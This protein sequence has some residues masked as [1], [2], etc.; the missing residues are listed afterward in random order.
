MKHL[1]WGLMVAA[2]VGCATQAQNDSVRAYG[3]RL[4][5]SDAV[6]LGPAVPMQYYTGDYLSVAS[7]GSEHLV[8]FYD[9]GRV[10]GVRLDEQGN[11]LDLERWLPLGRNDD[12]DGSQAYTDVTF[13]GGVYLVVYSDGQDAASGIYAQVVDPDGTL[14]S[15]PQ[16]VHP[17]GWYGAAVFNGTDFTVAYMGDGLGLTRVGVDGA[18][19]SETTTQVST[20][21]ATNRPVL[22]MADDV[23]LV[24]FE[25][26]VG[27]AERRVYAARFSPEGA[28]LDPG[29][30][31]ISDTTTSSVDVSVATSSSE[32]L[33]VWGGPAGRIY[34]SIVE[35]DGTVSR[36]EFPI[37]G[38][39][40]Y[41]GGSGVSFDGTNYLV[42]WQ[43]QTS[44]DYGIVGAR[45]STAGDRIDASDV[46]LAGGTRAGQS[47]SLDLSWTGT[48][49]ALVYV[50][51]DEDG[52]IKGV[53][54][55]S[56]LTP[57]HEGQLSLTVI[58]TSEQLHSVAFDG[59]DY[60]V[61][62]SHYTDEPEGRHLYASRVA[63]SGEL[64]NPEAEVVHAASAES[65]S[66]GAWVAATPSTTL[67]TYRVVGDTATTLLRSQ[68]DGGALSSPV[69]FAQTDGEYLQISSNGD[70]FLGIYYAGENANGNPTEIWG[71]AFDATGAP[72]GA[73]FLIQ[74]MERPAAQ[75]VPSGDGYLLVYA[76]QEIGGEPIVGSVLELSA[77]GQPVR[78]YGPFVDARIIPSA[79]SNGTYTLFAWS[80]AETIYGRILHQSDGYGEPFRISE[81]VA[82]GGVAAGWNGER[83]VVVW[84]ESRSAMWSREVDVEGLVTET[85]S[86]FDGDFISPRLTAGPDGQL[87]LSFQR[88]TE[89][90][91]SQR[92]ELRFLGA[93]DDP[94]LVDP[95]PVK[96]TG[97]AGGDIPTE[98]GAASGPNATGGSSADPPNAT[99]GSNPDV[100]VATGGSNPDVP[101]PTGGA[102]GKDEATGGA[103]AA[104]PGSEPPADE[105][106]PSAARSSQTSGGGCSIASPT[107]RTSLFPILSL[108]FLVALLRRRRRAC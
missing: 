97:G 40:T 25:Q 22:A 82:S 96:G 45:L 51:G 3:A 49:H 66:F 106:P 55:D 10:R 26:A 11:V 101:Q 92:A 89:F 37:S 94:A 15:D 69:E 63:P 80:D 38:E 14:L 39:G 73:G 62:W 41:P 71:Q 74:E 21:S 53:L 102:T 5:F 84:P 47:W 31:Q 91:R 56:D 76:G 19:L 48:H 107:H 70:T 27:D 65:Y 108:G 1:G 88:Y 46:P 12:A 75:L 35:L 60:V 100:P 29:G 93:G 52:G 43:D 85:T 4:T 61:A 58:P 13:G 7:S 98:G 33:A 44:S 57:L 99:G 79:A 105:T 28:V 32:F 95:P 16:L 36:T 23:G 68:T 81:G 78:D 59:E 54:L 104:A 8:S 24:V 6:F 72:V 9:G 20:E 77:E 86:M 17:S 18:V 83:F 2:L 67:Y 103:S 34:G 42:A 87:L 30:I 90:S 64:T 50:S